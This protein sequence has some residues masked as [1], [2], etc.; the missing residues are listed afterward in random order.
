[1]IRSQVPVRFLRLDKHLV[2]IEAIQQVFLS[3]DGESATVTL[4]GPRKS[5]QQITVPG[6]AGREIWQFVAENL[7]VAEFTTKSPEPPVVKEKATKGGKAH[8]KKAQA[9]KA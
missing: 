9:A 5:L 1:M 2:N 3:K 6:P 4:V 8:P 7:V